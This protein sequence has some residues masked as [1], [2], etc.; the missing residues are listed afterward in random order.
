MASIPNINSPKNESPKSPKKILQEQASL[1][2][3]QEAFRIISG[4]SGIL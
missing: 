3:A 4:D 2:D 1:E